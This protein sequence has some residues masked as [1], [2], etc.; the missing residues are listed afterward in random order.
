M[1]SAARRMEQ[2]VFKVSLD[3]RTFSNNKPANN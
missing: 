1:S 3:F 2:V